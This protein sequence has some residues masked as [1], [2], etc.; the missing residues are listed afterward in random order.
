[1]TITASDTPLRMPAT[2][3]TALEKLMNTVRILTGSW[4]SARR[5]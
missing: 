3:S 5:S 2:A 4:R 1:M